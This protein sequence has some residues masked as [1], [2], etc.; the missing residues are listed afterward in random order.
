MKLGM[1]GYILKYRLIIL[2]E[3][4]YKANFPLIFFIISLSLISLTYAVKNYFPTVFTFTEGQYLDFIYLCSIVL[5]LS[6][7][8]IIFR[9]E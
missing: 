1:I 2:R 3:W 4:I 5:I 6:M 8:G 9:K 7:I